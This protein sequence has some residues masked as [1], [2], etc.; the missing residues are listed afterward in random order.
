MASAP[1]I[2]SD[3]SAQSFPITYFND[4]KKHRKL[5]EII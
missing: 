2:F 4:S 5:R 1:N 3:P